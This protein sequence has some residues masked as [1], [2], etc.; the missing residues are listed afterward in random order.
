MTQSMLAAVQSAAAENPIPRV[1]HD[2]A[3]SA[4]RDEGRTSGVAEGRA[5]GAEAERVRIAAI[6]GH[7]E[8]AGRESLAQHY[9][10][11]TAVTPEEASA[12]LAAAP[13]AEAKNG[14]LEKLATSAPA[15]V[16]GAPP[17]GATKDNHG[18][19]QHIARV[20]SR[21]TGAA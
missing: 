20:N 10:F 17:A 2:A 3:V 7:A 21:L 13:K 12:A 4:A 11:K 16:L 19:G 5:L 18:W 6:L 1:E 14:A 9:A 15:V 8:A